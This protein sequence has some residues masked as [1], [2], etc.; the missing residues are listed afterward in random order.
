MRMYEDRCIKVKRI[1]VFFVFKWCLNGCR[2][3]L[4]WLSVMVV[5]VRGED[6]VRYVVSD[7]IILY[8]VGLRGYL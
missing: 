5:R 2:R 3:V 8:V 7:G 1:F 6:V 4:C